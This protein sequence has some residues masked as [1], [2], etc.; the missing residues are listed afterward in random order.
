M[1]ATYISRMIAYKLF[2]ISFAVWKISPKTYS[3]RTAYL[4]YD[5]VLHSELQFLKLFI[6]YNR[7]NIFERISVWRIFVLHS[8]FQ[9]LKL[10]ILYN[11]TNIFERIFVL[12]I[13]VLHSEFQ[14]LKLLILYNWT[15]IFLNTFER[16]SHN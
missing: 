5:F 16:K 12:R 13:F 1:E 3:T 2:D 8:E 11:W 14:N 15:N 9:N 7:T 4:C 10:F 6:L